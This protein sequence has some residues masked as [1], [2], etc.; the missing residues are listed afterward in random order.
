MKVKRI[1]VDGDS[2]YIHRLTFLSLRSHGIVGL[3]LAVSNNSLQVNGPRCSSADC[4]NKFAIK[5]LMYLILQ[6]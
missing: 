3:D 1:Y 2:I 6:F 4:I 5:E